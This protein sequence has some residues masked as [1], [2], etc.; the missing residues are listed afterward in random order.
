MKPSPSTTSPRPAAVTSPVRIWWPTITSAT[1]RTETGT[2]FLVAMT[3]S[4]ISSMLV[5]RPSP[6]TSSISP[7]R[8][9]LMLPPPTF[10][11][12]QFDG[13]HDFVERDVV[14][15]QAQGIDANL[16]LLFPVRPRS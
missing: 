6:C 9:S 7:E 15:H 8:F 2:P 16:V 1:S 11:L 3:I 10:R 14:P 5:V 4:L 12:F 13:G